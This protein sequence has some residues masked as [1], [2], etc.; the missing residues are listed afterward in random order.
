MTR[1][2]FIISFLIVSAGAFSNE[3]QD[4]N[5][6]LSYYR[7]GFYEIAE[8][9]FTE[10][11]NK[12]PSSTYKSKALYYLSLSQIKINKIKESVGNL[13]KI[14]NDKNFEYYN[15]A[16]Y[17]LI[18]GLFLTGENAKSES[19]I[20]NLNIGSFS[21]ERKEKIL[22]VS[23]VN[24]INLNNKKA[25]LAKSKT[26]FE[27]T[28]YVK[29][30]YEIQKYLLNYFI[31]NEDYQ[32]AVQ[33]FEAALLEN[34][35]P[36]T[37]K[38]LLFYNYVLSLSKLNRYDELIY[39]V[40]KYVDFFDDDIYKIFAD[41][42]YE[43][44]KYNESINILNIIHKN[45]GKDM[46]IIKKIAVIY[47][48][49]NDLYKAIETVEPYSNNNKEFIQ[50]LCDLYYRI[51][52][53]DKCRYYLSKLS[54]NELNDVNLRIFFNIANY[55]DKQDDIL[56][57]YD[58]ID[59]IDKFNSND[60]NQVL[61]KIAEVLYNRKIYDKCAFILDKWLKEFT[62]D[63]NYDKM[64]MMKAI[65]LKNDKRYEQ[66]IIEL[67]KIQKLKKKDALYYESFVEQGELY[68]TLREYGSAINCYNEYLNSKDYNERKKEVLLQLGNSYYNIKNFNNSYRTYAEYANIYGYSENLYV[69]IANSLI[70]SEKY[71]EL[72][73]YFSDKT[74]I[75]DYCQYMIVYSNYKLNN[76]AK[77]VNFKEINKN[78]AYLL[79]ALYLSA[80]SRAQNRYFDNIEEEYN[81]IKR[82]LSEK[83]PVK[84][85]KVVAIKKEYFKLFVRLNKISNL[86]NFF[87][88]I[89]SD[90]IYF[91]G[92]TYDKNLYYDEAKRH[93]NI[94]L[95]N[96]QYKEL[97]ENE[98]S[99][100][101][102]F[103]RNNNDLDSS[104]LVVDALLSKLYHEKFVTEKFDILIEKK[105]IKA[106][107][108][109]LNNEKTKAFKDYFQVCI[110]FEENGN[111]NEYKNGLVKLINN[112]KIN[113]YLSKHILLKYLKFEFN[114]NN[115]NTVLKYVT[116]ISDEEFVNLSPEIKY[117]EGLSYYQIGDEKSAVQLFLKM[118]YMYSQYSYWV[119]KAIRQV[120]SIY[121]K[122]GETERA[123]K[124]IEMFEDKFFKLRS[125]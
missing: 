26:Y 8:K 24:N 93:Y 120:V 90:I 123:N 83:D 23:I 25:S 81:Q 115:Y 124:A 34:K 101:F 111:K 31:T 5:L 21:E 86:D 15:E 88:I 87:S 92:Y 70:K 16:A 47:I 35:F 36:E 95:N 51:N 13:S 38:T 89:N 66:A 46:D 96:K 60:R 102:D 39:F 105:E 10:F 107:S 37:D 122:N 42:L 19:A 54:F 2:L 91:Q 116:K 45:N 18:L 109:I 76:Y 53:P 114:D 58:N 41:A 9:S 62:D 85:D 3:L 27:T 84:Y 94:L 52:N 14:S 43:T 74:G 75:G 119:E 71:A 121:S 61:Y 49:L 68:F 56:L 72:L 6:S 117:L 32:N 59:K 110:T 80:L 99:V 57:F 48:E 82:Y 112:K 17:Y 20:K 106:A 78:S 67:S 64:L 69:K 100:I 77:V 22:Y 4:F 63:V 50:M 11:V 29:Y 103:Y 98:L 65:T 108:E 104:L 118:F 113:T 55:F 28:G 1:L 125:L 33:I 12:N 79:D 97:S 30:R 7:D 44:K 73:N 40:N